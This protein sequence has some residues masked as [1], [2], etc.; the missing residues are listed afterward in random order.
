MFIQIN[1]SGPRAYGVDDRPICSSCGKETHIIRR[2]P[3]SASRQ[4]EIQ[5]FSCYA[6]R[7]EMTR[8]VDA[9]GNLRA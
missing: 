3:D 6:C 9:S 8:V 5:T 7:E 2:S 4:V 1:T